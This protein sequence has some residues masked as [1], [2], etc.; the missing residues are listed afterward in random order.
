MQHASLENKRNYTEPLER[1]SAPE[2]M[3]DPVLGELKISMGNHRL[4]YRDGQFDN[5]I[6]IKVKTQS[7][8]QLAYSQL[9]YI[10]NNDAVETTKIDIPIYTLSS[11][12]TIILESGGRIL[13]EWEVEGIKEDLPY[14]IFEKMELKYKEQSFPAKIMASVSR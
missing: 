4:K 9:A 8:E 5:P 14:L 13:K 3:L 6:Y 2:L 11:T 1:F 12:Y 10:Y 7:Q